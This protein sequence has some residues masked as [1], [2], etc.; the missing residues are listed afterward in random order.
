VSD[1]TL[2]VSVDNC[3]SLVPAEFEELE[4]RVG[5]LGGTLT[6]E[7]TRLMCELPCV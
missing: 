5:A 6:I 3:R 2:V 4:D 1:Q 7:G